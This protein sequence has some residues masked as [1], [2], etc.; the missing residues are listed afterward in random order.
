MTVSSTN[1]RSGPYTGNGST[2]QFD[3]T[4][5]INDQEHLR[6][7]LQEDGIE[8]DL[9][10]G[11]D[12]TVSGVGE[13]NGG[14]VTLATAPTSD[15]K[16]T[17]LRNVPFTQEVD[18]ENQG[19]YYAETVEQAFDLSVMRDQELSERLDR[20]VTIPASSD[21]S[22]L[23]ELVE[24]ILR[25]SDSAD[26][27]DTVAGVAG[28]VT[29][30]AG[31]AADVPTVAGIA[32]GVATVAGIADDVSTVAANAEDIGA[33]ADIVADVAT[34]AGI[35][36]PV[37]A[38]ATNSETI[39]AVAANAENINAVAGI[40]AEII[41]VPAQ[42]QAAAA[43]AT[44]AAGSAAAAAA[45]AAGVN[46][47]PIL[48]GDAGKQL[49]V[50]SD[51]TGYE[52]DDAAISNTALRP[53]D[54]GA[55]AISDWDDPEDSTAALAA[56]VTEVNATGKP[57][58]LSGV[59]A[60][61]DTLA[62]ATESLVIRG[63][64]ARQSGFLFRDCDGITLTQNG[65]YQTFS[66]RDFALLT[67]VVNTRKAFVYANSVNKTVPADLT[68]LLIMGKDRFEGTGNEHGWLE[69]ITLDKANYTHVEKVRTMGRE[70]DIAGGAFPTDTFGLRI[71]DSSQV[72]VNQSAFSRKKIGIEITGFSEGIEVTKNVLLANNVG[73]NASAG[74]TG[75]INDLNVR[76]NHIACF[77]RNIVLGTD[78]STISA[79]FHSISGNLFFS[80]KEAPANF[81]HVL[82]DG[83][84]AVTVSGNE[85]Y[86]ENVTTT[87]LPNTCI[88]GIG[89][90]RLH[91]Y[92][93][94]FF[95]C[96]TLV[97]LDA[98]S[99]TAAIHGNYVYDHPNT[100]GVAPLVDPSGNAT[101]GR[102]FGTRANNWLGQ[103][104]H[105]GANDVRLVNGQLKFPAT[106]S[107]SA[108]A[109]T[110]DD[111]EEGT[112]TPVITGTTAA[113]VGT[114][115]LQAGKYT[116]IGNAVLFNVDIAWTAH[117]GTGNLTI[118]GLPFTNGTMT[119]PLALYVSDLT[120]AAAVYAFVAG[121]SATITLCTAATG[122]AATALPM[123]NS[124]RLAL[125]GTLLL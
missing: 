57:V 32:G 24:D 84:N 61:R 88:Q 10:L 52:L 97:D 93:N 56:L 71:N 16:V 81:V 125:S 25:L 19:A 43:S 31:I 33:V 112:F 63:N 5:K 6:V 92:G 118:T 76:D 49:Y 98:D 39:N 11:T 68:G 72:Y 110:L 20:A 13:A 23:D 44:A 105:Y 104:L 95:F 70:G 47:P 65:A 119:I 18:L 124:G 111:Y 1:S 113:G 109:N 29:T 94:F 64:S 77:S 30:V 69:E 78:G 121:A 58:F 42:V 67:D 46:L 48:A 89:A 73:V 35:A 34:V 83:A 4:F 80:R 75:S 114:Y 59:Y 85:F 40:E 99:V 41:S 106:Q 7:I 28:D 62:F 117:T 60:T 12:Y 108:D 51:E 17:I 2:T 38:V 96:Y 3:Y 82:L 107:P 79:I 122:A 102:N 123:D 27:I 100:I 86:S 22:A 120:F 8:T 45:S 103:H 101:V 54:F 21:A 9:T 50:K 91:V 14:K 15:K 37:V 53:E 115:S 87:A 90:R 36:A 116:K 55:V 74:A 26:N 66:V